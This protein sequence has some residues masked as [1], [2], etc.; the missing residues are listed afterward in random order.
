MKYF[1]NILDENF[2]KQSEMGLEFDSKLEY[3]GNIIF[4]FITYDGDMDVVFAEKMIPVLSCIVNKKTFEYQA[5]SND[6]YLNY[7][8]MVNLPFLIDKLEWGTSIRGAWFDSSK[9]YEIDCGRIKIEKGEI[10]EFIQN[11]IEWV[12]S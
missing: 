11:L 12:H 3:L 4:D 9:E 8:M 2:E 10:E 5:E 7:L 6:N 1:K